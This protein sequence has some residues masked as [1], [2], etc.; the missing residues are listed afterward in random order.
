METIRTYL[1]NMFASLPKTEEV[2]RMKESLFSDMA[3]HY[4]ALKQEGRS[5]HEAIATVIGEFGNFDELLAE[6]NLSSD[7]IADAPQK[8]SGLPLVSE[9]EAR[10]FLADNKKYSRRIAWGVFLC[11]VSPLLLIASEWIAFFGRLITDDV[12]A[13]GLI[14]LF[15]CVAAAVAMFI[16]SG[17][18]MN[19][20][21]YMEEA[22]ELS[23]SLAAILRQEY[24]DFTP[25]Y[26][27]D[28]V[29]GVT[30]CILGP[31][32]LVVSAVLFDGRMISELYITLIVDLM[33][34]MIAVAVFL[35]IRSCSRRGAYQKLLQ[36][37]EYTVSRKKNS[38][39]TGAV[40]S[41]VFPLAAVA[42]LACGF[43]G[44][45]WDSAWVIFPLVGICYG[46]FCGIYNYLKREEA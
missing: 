23:P 41:V 26:T 20:Y 44:D 12:A 18:C 33:L 7:C 10:Q 25:A 42:Y 28:I 14:W 16:H 2:V 4:D 9:E 37:E 21:R 22:L 15:L 32:I 27:R 8:S 31:M 29:L 6:L 35:F 24:E 39:A 45:L 19:R 13:L 36:I 5:E 38:G 17:I 11:I 1:D 43:I 40:A 46:A 3:D 34:V 30:L